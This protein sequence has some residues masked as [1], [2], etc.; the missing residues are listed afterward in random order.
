MV[1]D[2]ITNLFN[3]ASDSA[4]DMFFD[5]DLIEEGDEDFILDDADYWDDVSMFV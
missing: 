1:M 2:L 3:L 5:S 4:D